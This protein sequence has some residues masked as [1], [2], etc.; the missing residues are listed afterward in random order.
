M[1]EDADPYLAA[2]AQ[3]GSDLHSA[4]DR[5]HDRMGEAKADCCDLPERLESAGRGPP[6]PALVQAHER[7]YRWVLD[8]SKSTESLGQVVSKM[9][10]VW[11][12]K[13]GLDPATLTP[14]LESIVKSFPEC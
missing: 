4:V 1:L 9:A 7:R 5:V 6:C 14:L 13:R 12:E 10:P 8:A 3:P 2:L 11:W